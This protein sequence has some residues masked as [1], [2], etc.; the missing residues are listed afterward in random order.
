MEEMIMQSNINYIKGLIFDEQTKEMLYQTIREVSLE[1]PQVDIWTDE[2]CYDN[3]VSAQESRMRYDVE[4]TGKTYGAPF[5]LVD[6]RDKDNISL[7]HLGCFDRS[8]DFNNL[9]YYDGV[10]D[11]VMEIVEYFRPFADETE[12][13]G[14]SIEDVEDILG[15]NLIMLVDKNSMDDKVFEELKKYSIKEFNTMG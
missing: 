12:L 5:T 6:I 1:Q 7:L 2:T 15:G 3:Y 14:L 9:E 13:M 4:R 8:T 10:T 11:T